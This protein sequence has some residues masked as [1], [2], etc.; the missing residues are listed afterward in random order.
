MHSIKGSWVGQTFALAKNNESEGRRS[1]I[2]RSKEERKA[3]VESF[4]KKY[5][6]I[7]NGSFP[8]LNLTHKEV[9]GS[10]YT[11]REIVRDIIQENRVLGPAKFTVEEQQTID[12]FWEHN[13][14]GTIAAE[15]QNTLSIS[16]NELLFVT[17]QNQGVIEQLVF[18]S[19]GHLVA[20]EH[21]MF[22]NGRIINGTQVEVNDKEFNEP[23][24]TELQ[25]NGPVEIEKHVAVESI[26]SN[27]H[28][29]GPEY[30]SFD[31]G[32]INGSQIDRKDKEREE[33]MCT[34]L[35]T[36]EPSEAE[37]NAE[38]VRATSKSNVNPLTA[39]VIV[40]T[41]PL[42]PVNA[43]PEG[44]DGRLQEVTDLTKSSKDKGT[45]GMELAGVD[46]LQVD[47]LYSM[48]SM[49]DN[50][51]MNLS[52]PL[53]ENK[54]SPVDEALGNAI[55]PSVESSSYST[56]NEGIVHETGST[57]L[58]VKSPHKDVPT[59]EISNQNQLTAGTKAD[60]AP[61]SLHTKI[62][63][64]TSGSSEQSKTKEVVVIEDE[65]DVQTS[66]S[67]KKGSKPTLDRINLESWE[68]ASKKTRPEGNPLWDVFKAFLDALVKF[69]SE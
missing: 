11:V 40:E 16:S 22:E 39:D 51:A 31:N 33:R 7:N 46:S 50:V 6:K 41:F 9:G 52:S 8:S 54:S 29:I 65:V 59:S 66:G 27:G 49:D 63:N 47:R 13:P 23:K 42:K 15:P 10:F 58:N 36:V 24:S 56:F 67:L 30:Q 19:D 18:A 64:G 34:E 38:D 53:V 43:T 5:Q 1:R 28:C 61:D 48:K 21:Q 4:I 62:T 26:D 2:R 55:D 60:K 35:Q 17:N 57:D 32:L 37:K 3:M 25:A 44:L 20:P 14:L 12:Q 69:W 45:R 68:G